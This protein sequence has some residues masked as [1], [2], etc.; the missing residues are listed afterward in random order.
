VSQ[1]AQVLGTDRV[2]PGLHR[3]RLQAPQGFGFAAGQF[4]ILPVPPPPGAEPGGK[5]LKGFYS[6][7]SAPAALPLLELLVEHREGGGPVSAWVSGRAAGEALDFEGPLGHFGLIDAEG[8]CAF[9]GHRAGL[10][11]L[12]SL[13]LQALAQGR[14]AWLFLGGESPA[15]WLLDGEWQ[16]LAGREPRFR[17]RPLLGGPEALAAAAAA[18]APAEARFHLAGFTREVQPAHEALLAAGVPAARLKMEK[19]G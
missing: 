18:E 13:L 4:I 8:P 5:P 12:R 2:A 11:P 19:F 14:E 6:I 9:L 16:A 10:A 3:L 7:A 1:R 17:Y 15:E